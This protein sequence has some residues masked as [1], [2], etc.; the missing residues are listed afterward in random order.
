MRFQ[1]APQDLGA[2]VRTVY[3]RDPD[4]NV[5]EL[6]ELVGGARHPFALPVP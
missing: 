5:V 1:S 4:G 3:A 6:K 2:G